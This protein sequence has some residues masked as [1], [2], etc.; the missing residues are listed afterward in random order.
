MEF[1]A[2]SLSCLR[3]KEPNQPNFRCKTE[4]K[5]SDRQTNE[6]GV[7]L[8]QLTLQSLLFQKHFI[9]K[10]LISLKGA[11]ELILMKHL[12]MYKSEVAI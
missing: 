4:G 1:I 2:T 10:K 8:L 11:Q 12:R 7:P 5:F 9:Q 3:N 6:V